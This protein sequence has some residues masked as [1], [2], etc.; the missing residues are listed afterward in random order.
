ME[1]VTDPFILEQLNIPEPGEVTD[2]ALL[3]LL[4]APKK[5]PGMAEAAL[6]GGAQ[7]A[8]FG[9][10]D[11]L[12]AGV[13]ALMEQGKGF[14]EAYEEAIGPIR[15]QYEAAR[16]AHP[17]TSTV[18]E[19]AGAVVP[20]LIAPESLA[21]RAGTIPGAAAMGALYAAGTTKELDLEGAKDVML[22]GTLGAAVPPAMKVMSIPLK[23]AY[24]AMNPAQQAR[25]LMIAKNIDINYDGLKRE[26]MDVIPT[27]KTKE[28]QGRVKGYEAGTVQRGTRVMLGDKGVSFDG[29][30][31]TSR[32]DMPAFTFIGEDLPGGFM[33]GS[34][35]NELSRAKDF[36]RAIVRESD[37]RNIGIEE[38]T[39][40]TLET[41]E[42]KADE[43]L[44]GLTPQQIAEQVQR[45]T[46][47]TRPLMSGAV[48]AGTQKMGPAASVVFGNFDQTGKFISANK[49]GFT[50]L[51]KD[52]AEAAHKAGDE[53]L[54][55]LKKMGDI[56]AFHLGKFLENYTPGLMD[57]GSYTLFTEDLTNLVDKTGIGS[58]LKKYATAITTRKAPLPD[59]LKMAILGNA[60]DQYF[61]EAGVGA[62]KLAVF[63]GAAG[64]GGVLFGRGIIDPLGTGAALF[65]VG[66]EALSMPG[67]RGTILKTLE[68]PFPSSMDRTLGR[69]I[70]G[71][72]KWAKVLS[73]AAQKGPEEVA[74]VDF[75]LS[76]IDPDYQEE[77]KNYQEGGE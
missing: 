62:G 41:I 16:E 61:K 60:L 48:L 29:I 35:G 15:E 6:R 2:P 68:R 13:Q 9:F 70:Q 75:V 77:K 7:G 46:W 5:E 8:T 12:Q 58:I 59:Y 3:A 22:G 64:L 42:K 33:E 14:K 30:W 73:D 31:E 39:E 4:N 43:V 19:V 26:A 52:A 54:G 72:G 71:G 66:K 18:G 25:R 63:M 27:A 38:I 37:P 10:S 67:V 69:M 74:V 44:S 49:I 23:W 55:Y 56:E 40:N 34:S 45:P 47:A 53:V 50:T 36:F 57:Q 1:E 11:E 20:S 65:T 21:A 76:Q 51:E 32:G 17:I 28:L 24:K